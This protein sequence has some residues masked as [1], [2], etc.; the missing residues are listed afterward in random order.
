MTMTARSEKRKQAAGHVASTLYG[1]VMILAAALAVRPGELSLAAGV[2][3]ALGV[4]LAILATRCFT[5]VIKVETE[6]GRHIEPGRMAQILKAQTFVMAFPLLTAAV[7]PAALAL[8]VAEARVIDLVFYLGA[9]SVFLVGFASSYLV[10]GR[11][12]FALRRGCYWLL[13]S[14]VLLAAKKLG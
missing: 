2:V 1:V 14:A 5:E 3:G 10:D 9:V 13:F 12:G 6:S 8:G 4:G 11:P 7:I